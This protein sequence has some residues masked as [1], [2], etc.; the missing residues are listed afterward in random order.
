[1]GYQWSVGELAVC[2]C[3]K[4]YLVGENPPKAGFIYTVQHFE[5]ETEDMFTSLWFH[6]IK[7]RINPLVPEDNFLGTGGYLAADFRPLNE[8]DYKRIREKHGEPR[9][10]VSPPWTLEEGPMIL[11]PETREW[12]QWKGI[13]F[14]FGPVHTEVGRWK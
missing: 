7:N 6:E 5:P 10:L 3:D 1:M 12:V 8:D 14:T 11:D 4:G 9:I 2:I 13:V